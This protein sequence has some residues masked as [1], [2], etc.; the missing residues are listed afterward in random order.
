MYNMEKKHVCMYF[1]RNTKN[2]GLFCSFKLIY[3]SPITHS[4]HVRNENYME[5]LLERMKNIHIQGHG[6]INFPH[7]KDRKDHS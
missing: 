7:R 6:D 4:M 1:L 5:K 3:Q 2:I